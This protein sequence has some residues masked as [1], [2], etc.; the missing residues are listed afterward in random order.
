MSPAC[1]RMVCPGELSAAR[2]RCAA[3]QA[4]PP[5]SPSDSRCPCRSLSPSSWIRTTPGGAASG[6]VSAPARSPSRATRP[7]ATKAAAPGTRGR[8]ST[9]GLEATA[10]GDAACYRVRSASE[11]E[12]KSTG[13]GAQPHPPRLDALD[14][15]H[16]AR[17]RVVRQAAADRR[18]ALSLDHVE[19][20]LAVEVTHGAAEDDEALLDERVHEGRVLVP[21]VLLAPPP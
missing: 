17:P 12:V 16:V 19:G 14:G 11:L 13:R 1:T 7:A 6:G 2:S 20:V 21:P 18:L 8:R 5:T 10:G 4:A 15:Q 3:S 9:P